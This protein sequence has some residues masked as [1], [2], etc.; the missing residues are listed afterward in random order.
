MLRR[1]AIAWAACALLAA[2]ASG[3][4]QDQTSKKSA[5]DPGGETVR[6]EDVT[7]WTVTEDGRDYE[8]RPA[9]PDY[10]GDTGLFHLPSAYTLPRGKFSFGLFRDNLDRDPK[11][12]DISV[13]GGS[14]A[15]GITRRF[16]V[17]AG[18]GFQNRIDADALF[19]AGFV[20]DYPFVASP[21]QTG[22]G[23]I[24]IGGKYKFLDD[25]RGDPVAFAARAYVKLPTAD[26]A[27]G[28]GT[29]KASFGGDLVLSKGLGRVVDVHGS[30]GY[31]I[32]GDPSDVNIGNAFK[33][34]VGLNTPTFKKVQL[35]AEV[36][37]A[38]YGSADVD[39]TNPVD[40]VIGPVIWFKP[41]LFLRAALSWNA[42]FND[43]GLGSSFK[44]YSDYQVSLGYHPGT[45]ARAVAVP[46]PPVAPPPA[47][48]NP[49]VSCE[50][51]RGQA[52]PGESVRLRASG[53]DP[54]GDALTYEWTASLGRVTGSGATAS[55]DTT[56]VAAPSTV[57]V[58]VRVSDGRGGTAS[59][60][61]SVRVQGPERK[62]ETVTCSSGGFPRNLARLNNVDKACLD[63]VASRLRQD[64]RSRVIVVGHAD[65]QER[66]PEVVARTRAEAVKSYLVR[67][68]GVDES[69]VSV[70]SAGASRLL[71]TGTTAAARARNRRVEV[72]FVPEGAAAP[73]ED[74]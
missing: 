63:D 66:R 72:I 53:S 13:L 67:E 46:P 70:R 43:R 52:L 68:R 26:D 59:S 9:T 8:V 62:T 19:Q 29:G 25:Y 69:R 24:G 31:Q 44:S 34:G 1:S 18:F 71:D 74:D 35:Q 30:I 41:G 7:T 6:A 51:E 61:C 47:N 73:E 17:Y 49:T 37:G 65:G 48:R 40:F 2:A 33:W 23:D 60:T 27:K 22:V 28:L 5:D 10:A 55:L 50:A 42:N 58:T 45:L 36:T 56:G 32:N 15:Y 64:P 39:Q 38:V 12:Q 14:F 3:T 57:T 20:N 4:A 16:E 54:D 21:W 11:D